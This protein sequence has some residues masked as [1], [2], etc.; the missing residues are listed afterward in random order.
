MNKKNS[1][2]DKNAIT[3]TLDRIIAHIMITHIV[4][5]TLSDEIAKN[6]TIHEINASVRHAINDVEKQNHNQTHLERIIEDLLEAYRYYRKPIVQT[7]KRAYTKKLM[8]PY[9]DKSFLFRTFYTGLAKST[10][11]HVDNKTL[12]GALSFAMGVTTG[13]LHYSQVHKI[14]DRAGIPKKYGTNWLLAAE[15]VMNFFSTMQNYL[16]LEG[17]SSL[18]TAITHNHMNQEIKN[19]LVTGIFIARYA[20]TGIG[21]VMNNFYDRYL[22]NF[23]MY[24]TP[25]SAAVMVASKILDMKENGQHN[26]LSKK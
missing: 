13:R 5:E 26:N 21:V 2:I 16:M 18:Y 6:Y 19:N 17:A 12:H 23:F 3:Q 25:S 9:K 11:A 7:L 14:F 4:R 15:G 22:T 20:W 24:A 1:D 10:P 8:E